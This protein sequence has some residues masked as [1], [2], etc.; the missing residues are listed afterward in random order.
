MD[1][2]SPD[3]QPSAVPGS[4]PNLSKWVWGGVVAVLFLVLHI[5]ALVINAKVASAS[6]EYAHVFLIPFISLYLVW[7]TRVRLRQVPV[8]TCWWGLPLLL[9]GVFQYLVV[10]EL[11][12]ATPLAFYMIFNL[13]ALVLF[14][15]GFRMALRLA[16][17][18]AYLLFAVPTDLLLQPLSVRLQGVAAIGAEICL[19]LAG[20][21]LDL[22]AERMGS[23]LQIFH[24]GIP[25]KPPLNVEEACSGLRMLMAFAALGVAMAYLIQNR[26]RWFRFTLMAAT[27]PIAI[28]SNILR[29]TGMGLAYPWFPGITSGDLH[30]ALGL[31]ML[32][33]AIFLFNL[34]ERFLN[35]VLAV[36]SPVS[37]P[38]PE[39]RP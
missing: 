31:L 30:L 16:V 27:L 37:V 6:A 36:I 3:L 5:P 7:Q 20:L 8:W 4:A 18:V 38:S 13:G 24:H 14:L 29:I 11:G 35:L 32:V 2:P 34:T 1:L 28:F 12:R 10:V 19:N 25:L 23:T 22:D 33:P 26:P 39:G 17:P 9:W 15:L 21:L